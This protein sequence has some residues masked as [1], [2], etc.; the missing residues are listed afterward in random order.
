M[1]DLLFSKDGSVGAVVVGVG[2]FLGIGEKN[3]AV[4]FEALESR[5]D[6]NGNVTLYINATAE[7]LD[8]APEFMTL[9]QIQAEERARAADNSTAPTPAPAM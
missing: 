3:V 6:E 8:A 2:G 9:A 4:P 5:A 1:N 7:Q